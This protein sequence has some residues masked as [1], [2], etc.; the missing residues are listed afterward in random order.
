M[1]NFGLCFAAIDSALCFVEM[2]FARCLAGIGFGN[3]SVGPGSARCSARIGYARCLAVKGLRR[4]FFA[5]GFARRL[6]GLGSVTADFERCWIEPGSA[7][8]S[9]TIDSVRH[10]V[11]TRSER[12]WIEI[13][14]GQYFVDSAHRSVAVD[15]GL[16]W[17]EPG[18]VRRCFVRPGS[19]RYFVGI[20]S[21]PHSAGTDFGRNSARFGSAGYSGPPEPGR[22][23]VGRDFQRRRPGNLYSQPGRL[24]SSALD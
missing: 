22:R 24:P 19:A 14:C 12:C 18:F 15:F 23:F 16:Y 6:P 10:S 4:C 7:R 20:G 1:K 8:C 17:I 9:A 11:A 21:E 3:C 5:V 13:G 2:S